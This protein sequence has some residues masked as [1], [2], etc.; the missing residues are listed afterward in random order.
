LDPPSCGSEELALTPQFLR[1]R[2]L[3]YRYLATKARREA[4]RILA[5][6]TAPRLIELAEKLERD[7]V[8]DEEEASVLAAEQEAG[9]SD[10][11]PP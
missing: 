6:P 10:Q 3:R 1:A 2:A 5:D 11:L 9:T 4:C 7:A 8:R